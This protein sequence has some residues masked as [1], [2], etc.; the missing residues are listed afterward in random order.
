MDAVENDEYSVRGCI[1]LSDDWDHFFDNY[2]ICI[3]GTI[4][5]YSKELLDNKATRPLPA[6]RPEKITKSNSIDWP[7]AIL[8]AFHRRKAHE[9]FDYTVYEDAPDNNV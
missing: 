5:E 9:K 2:Y 7:K 3:N 4:I 8:F 6:V 1:Y